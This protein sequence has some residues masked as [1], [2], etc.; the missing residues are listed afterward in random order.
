MT[1]KHHAGNRKKRFLVSVREVWIQPHLV[2]AKTAEEALQKVAAADGAMLEDRFE[3]S[4][5]LDRDL[6]TVEEE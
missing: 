5:T 3:Y 2:E 4:H 6:W 1:K